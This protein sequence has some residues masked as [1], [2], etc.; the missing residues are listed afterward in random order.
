MKMYRMELDVG[1]M[2]VLSGLFICEDNELQT[3]IGKEGYFDECLGKHS[4]IN[5]PFEME[6]FE[7]IPVSQQTIDEFLALT[8]TTISGYN[9][10]LYIS[11]D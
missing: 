6:D 9:P 5:W 7:E 1:R 10:F 2:G 8:G 11:Q 4:E 3:I